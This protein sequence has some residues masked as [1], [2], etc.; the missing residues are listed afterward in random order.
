MNQAPWPR[1]YTR[2]TW[3]VGSNCSKTNVVN[4][5]QASLQVSDAFDALRCAGSPAGANAM[6]ANII[7]GAT[8]NGTYYPYP[9]ASPIC[10]AGFCYGCLSGGT[11]QAGTTTAACG[12]G[13]VQCVACG[14]GQTCLNGV[15]Q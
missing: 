7:D 9:S 10:R 6:P 4:T 12:T 11:C 14:G 15:C 3:T 1:G 13:G 8:I 5:G 2:R